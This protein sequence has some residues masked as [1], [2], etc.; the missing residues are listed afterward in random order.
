MVKMKIKKKIK[1]KIKILALKKKK[2]GITDISKLRKAKVV[3]DAN[4]KVISKNIVRGTL[5][6]NA[7]F[8]S[9]S[10]IKI[11]AQTLFVLDA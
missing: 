11:N 2:K 1:M 7:N 9:D 10:T 8:V 3:L 6:K 5:K 4:S